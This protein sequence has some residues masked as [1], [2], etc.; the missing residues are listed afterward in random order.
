MHSDDTVSPGWTSH[1]PTCLPEK[2]TLQDS[3]ADAL[4]ELTEGAVGADRTIVQYSLRRPDSGQ[5]FEYFK[6][7]S[8]APLQLALQIANRCFGE[9][10]DAHQCLPASYPLACFL[11]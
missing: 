4:A 10:L 9:C 6:L 2:S 3:E 7:R 5:F 1:S 8:R 11:H